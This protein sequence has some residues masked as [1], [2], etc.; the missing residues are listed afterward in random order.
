MQVFIVT[1]AGV[2]LFIIGGV[3]IYTVK[4]RRFYRR[5]VGG[6][7]HFRTYSGSLVTRLLEGIA[8]IVGIV[9]LIIGIMIIIGCIHY[10]MTRSKKVNH[11]QTQGVSK[12]HQV[13][14][15]LRK[16]G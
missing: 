2:I 16:N 3:L 14:P 8:M 12:M 5:G 9:L 11:K 4:R 13:E 7:Q 6:L 10:E 15:F 1:L